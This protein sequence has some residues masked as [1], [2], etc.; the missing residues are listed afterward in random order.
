MIRLKMNFVV[1]F[2]LLLGISTQA[3]IPMDQLLACYSFE[4]N[5]EDPIGGLDGTLVGDANLD[6]N[7][8]NVGYNDQD[9]FHVPGEILNGSDDFTIA[10]WIKFN[11]FFTEHISAGATV[12][13]CAL[14]DQVTNVGNLVYV[15]DQLLGGGLDLSNCF[16][17]AQY[18]ELY[19]FDNISLEPFVAYHLAMSKEGNELRL[20][21][22]GVEQNGGAPL[23]VPNEAIYMADTG[24]V[25]GQDQDVL[26]GGYEA[27]QAMNGTMDDLFIYARGLSEEEVNGIMNTSHEQATNTLE[28]EASQDFIFEAFP[29][30]SNTG[31]FFI[32]HKHNSSSFV[33]TVYDQSGKLL[34]E[35]ESNEVF[36]DCLDLSALDNGIYTLEFRA[37]L[38]RRVNRVII[39]K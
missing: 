16:Y 23:Y 37:G 9:A 36:N 14:N 8:L 13:S 12:F 5:T 26:A 18:G 25:F 27:F 4:G 3:Q 28:L 24:F 33:I 34:Q 38:E 31:K 10:M 20:F 2:L 15:K 22:N 17:W 11:G 7:V 35:F 39:S 6:L 30:P 19:I 29:N 32:K 21:I 1:F